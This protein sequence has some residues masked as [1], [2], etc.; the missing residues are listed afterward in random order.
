MDMANTGVKE[1]HPIC[2]SRGS[3][4]LNIVLWHTFQHELLDITISLGHPI[5]LCCQSAHRKTIDNVV[6]SSCQLVYRHIKLFRTSLNL[7][8][9]IRLKELLFF[10]VLVHFIRENLWN[11]SA[12]K[13]FCCPKN[14]QTPPCFLWP[15]RLLTKHVR[16]AGAG[17]NVYGRIGRIG[18]RIHNW[19][20]AWNIFYFLLYWE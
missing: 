5:P 10:H 14:I 18:R 11:S 4:R 2:G 1:T 6:L 13:Q 15:L 12:Q 9:S 19:L 20:V 17:D 3:N 16:D 7:A 8:G